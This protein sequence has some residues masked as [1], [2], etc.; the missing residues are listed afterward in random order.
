MGLWPETACLHILKEL[1]IKEFLKKSFCN[2]LPERWC[3]H[4]TLLLLNSL[5]PVKEHLF[6]ACKCLGRVIFWLFMTAGE[7]DYLFHFTWTKRK[8]SSSFQ[9][10]VEF[11]TNWKKPPKPTKQT[12]QFRVSFKLKASHETRKQ[13]NSFVSTSRKF[14]PLFSI[15]AVCQ[16]ASNSTN[17]LVCHQSTPLQSKACI[18]KL[19][20]GVWTLFVWHHGVQQGG[21]LWAS[22]YVE[23]NVSTVVLD[24]Q[25]QLLQLEHTFQKE[26]VWISR[27]HN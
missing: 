10:I 19:Q 26:P 8:P 15:K 5:L 12:K 22:L 21:C 13:R 6:S 16:F 9:R 18:W 2:T 25:T 23:L 17:N 1:A 11:F 27:L 24:Y 7:P 14:T 4:L 3:T 20:Q